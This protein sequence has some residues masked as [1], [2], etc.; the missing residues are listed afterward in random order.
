VSLVLPCF[1]KIIGEELDG[2]GQVITVKE[3]DVADK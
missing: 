3:S 2:E 1:E